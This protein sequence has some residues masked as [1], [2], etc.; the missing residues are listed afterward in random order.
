MGAMPYVLLGLA[1]VLGLVF[2]VSAWSK[3]RSAA[4][5]RAFAASL[6]PLIP[7]RVGGAVAGALTAAEVVVALC[8]AATAV[9]VLVELP[10]ARTFGIVAMLLAAGLC[11]ALTV[12]VAVTVRRHLNVRCAC[13]GAA[14]R[15]LSGRHVVR[16]A[17]LLAVA[18]AGL[19]TAA[20][21]PTTPVAVA[22]AVVGVGAGAVAALIL[23]RL[24]DVV[25]LFVPVR[26]TR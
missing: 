20:A 8:L 21:G 17:I 26:T 22:G 4:A 11:A 3:V 15:Q 14:E 13:F 2:G 10:G 12:G 6:R 5:Q 9:A 25:D 19:G 16:N 24:D 18:L 23:I 1:A 7:D